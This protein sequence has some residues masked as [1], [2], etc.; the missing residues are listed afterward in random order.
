MIRL[1]TLVNEIQH[2][3]NGKTGYCITDKLMA[4]HER[5]LTYGMNINAIRFPACRLVFIK[6][7]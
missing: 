4:C 1:C 7:G 5:S 6:E 2:S 3:L